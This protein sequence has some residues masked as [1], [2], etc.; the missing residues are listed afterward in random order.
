[1]AMK[2]F[3]ALGDFRA[4]VLE[5]LAW[6][7]IALS[8]MWAARAMPRCLEGRRIGVI[9]E[10]PGWRN[11]AALA[12]GAAEMGASCVPVAVSLEGGEAVEDLAGYL[13]NWFDCLAVR[14]PSLEKLS[15]L[16]GGMQAAVLNLRT[17]DNHPVEVLADLT[18]V[19]A[20]RG[21]WEGLKVAVVAP[22][23]NILQSWIEA[24]A[25][26]PIN[27]VQVSPPSYFAEGHS[28]GVSQSEDMGV[29]T[30]ADLIVTDCWPK[31]AERA[32]FAK[33][34]VTADVLDAC[35]IDAV[36]I[37]CPPVTRGQEV[38]AEAMGHPKCAARAAK[39]YLLHVQ[40][41]VLEDLLAG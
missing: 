12:L 15:A 39:D 29:L 9:S 21:S 33:L 28:K 18:F 17:N 14:T 5:A 2:G 31:G 10:L 37:P 26:L 40:N 4:Q 36:F 3:L 7:A 38:S 32:A 30:E 11:P 16:A 25:V 13:D 41:A 19:L 24:A 8:E 1:M 35:Q 22:K 27:V 34:R 20:Q 6:R 23:G